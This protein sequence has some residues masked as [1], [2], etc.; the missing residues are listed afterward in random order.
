MPT[1]GTTTATTTPAPPARPVTRQILVFSAVGVV[2]TGTY[3]GSYLLLLTRLPYFAAHLLGFLISMTGSFFLNARFTY[4]I[5]PTWRKFLLFPLTN[6]T[7]FTLT[8]AGLYLIV[9]VTHSDD[10]LAPLLASGA[11]IPVT[12]LVS[13]MIMQPKPARNAARPTPAPPPAHSTT[14]QPS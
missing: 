13:R 3:Y 12:F 5:R 7:N 11:A 1:T 10:R 8:T 4:R 9:H 6:A 2:N 14:S